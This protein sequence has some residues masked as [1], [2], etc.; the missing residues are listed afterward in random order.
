VGGKNVG[1]KG[2]RYMRYAQGT[3]LANLHLTLLDRISV[4]LEKFGDS[5]GSLDNLGDAILSAV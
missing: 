3:P 4:P 5:T 2:G 1:I